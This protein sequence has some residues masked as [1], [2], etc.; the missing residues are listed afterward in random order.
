MKMINELRRL[1]IVSTAA[2]ALGTLSV[3]YAGEK[4]LRFSYLGKPGSDQ[5]T[6][7][8]ELAKRVNSET[9]G[10]V[11]IDTY[12]ASQLGDWTEVQELVMQGAVDFSLQPMST[13][14]DKSVA[15][16][17][18]PYAV[19]DY[20]SA[21]KAFSEGG[22]INDIV[23]ESSKKLGLTILGA[24]PH[25]MGGSGFVK[26]VDN[27][28]GTEGSKQLKVR[29][30]PGGTTHQALLKR[31]GYQTAPVAWSEL[32]TSLQTGVVDGAIGGTAS[33][34]VDSF[35]DITKMWIQYNDHFEL[36]WIFA[37]TQ[38]F[39]KLSDADQATFK[40]I[41]GELSK[42]RYADVEATDKAS[43]EKLRKAGVKVVEFTPEEM[44]NL[45]KVVRE[46]VWPKIADEIGESSY[47]MLLEKVKQ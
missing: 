33:D 34:Q 40:K 10:R 14:F 38:T 41:L 42:Q 47:N 11:K 23:N 1:M 36:G 17:W 26:M 32:Y 12:P 37:N 31:L 21:E 8:K 30:W 9:D 46:D 24:Y 43:M 3:S 45:V 5:D 44:N 2:L 25:G 19:T 27:P 39:E 7:V 4:A 15:L 18:F 35:L 16:A 20:A 22:Y 13:K 28:T 6:F 29:V